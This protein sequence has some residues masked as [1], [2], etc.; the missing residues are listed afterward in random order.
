MGRSEHPWKPRG[1]VLLAVYLFGISP[2]E[3]T[4]PF[5]D[6]DQAPPSS[7]RQWNPPN[8]GRYQN[9]L[10][11]G[12]AEALEKGK[13]LV[14]PQKEYRLPDLIDLAEQL[15][16]ATR[17]AWQNAKA[18]LALVGVA[19]STYYPYLSLA[20]A[21]GYT[22]LF[23]P[24]PKIQINQAALRSA[25]ASGRLAPNVVTLATGNPIHFDVLYQSELTMNWLLFDFGQ[26]EANVSAARDG[27]L[28][29]NVGF[30]ATHQ[31]VVFEVSQ[32]FYAYNLARESTKVAE[33]AFQ[34]AETVYS[35]VDARVRE[36]LATQPDLLQA[37]Q[38]LAQSRYDLERARGSERDAFV[39]MMEAIGLSPSVP[40]RV[41]QGFRLGGS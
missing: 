27:L 9:T 35:A 15:N 33:S 37:S 6:R 31:R 16:P 18:A 7:R 12:T 10:R 8:L 11:Q 40:I 36:G 17:A 24:A 32:S 29:A 25:L 26:R 19:K 21:A 23:V 20:A 3:A 13:Q 41:S 22:R 28:I 39:D 1:A 34:T 30:N 4:F 2:A 38:Q 5:S 14:D